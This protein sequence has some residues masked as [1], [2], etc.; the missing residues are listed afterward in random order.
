MFIRLIRNEL[1][2]KGMG[3]FVFFGLGIPGWAL[4]GKSRLF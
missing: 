1:G 3:D 2:V 4:G